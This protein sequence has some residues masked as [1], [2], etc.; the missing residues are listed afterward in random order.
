MRVFFFGDS[1]TQGFF[2]EKGG[3]AQRL[4]NHYHSK[5]RENLGQ[6][7]WIECF[8]LG[9]SGDT[10]DG[11]IRR[12]E[13][14]VTNRQLLD[15]ENVIV[16]AIGINDTVLRDNRAVR[17]VYDFQESFE[18][19]LNSSLNIADKVICIGLTAVDE[20]LTDPVAYS[21]TNE[22]YLNNRINLFEDTI[23]QACETKDLPFVPVHD[24]FLAQ[25]ESAALLSDGLHPNEA[26]HELIANLVKPHLD[27]LL[28]LQQ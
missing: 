14:E 18:K 11:L 3:W 28:N 9:V 1:I 2:D 27:K 12:I 21:S 20:S 16:L 6:D 7:F 22:Q 17:D 26:G 15:D 10:V 4:I 13:L 19:L 8:N 5:T 25:S 24:R 23:K